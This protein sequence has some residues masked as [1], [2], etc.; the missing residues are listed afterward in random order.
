[1]GGEGARRREEWSPPGMVMVV[2][3]ETPCGS[4]GDVHFGRSYS[5][6]IP[7]P[8]ATVGCPVG[9]TYKDPIHIQA[10]IPGAL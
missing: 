5:V 1:M 10:G 6:H 9:H 7:A 3:R 8:R 4:Q 2:G